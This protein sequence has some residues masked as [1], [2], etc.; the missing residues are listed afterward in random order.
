MKRLVFDEFAL[1]Q[2]DLKYKKHELFIE[3]LMHDRSIQKELFI[4]KEQFVNFSR[5]DLLSNNSFIVK[6]DDIPVG[7]I[8][9]SLISNG[10]VSLS[11][12][13]EKSFRNEGY[14]TLIIS[15]LSDYL[16][17][18]DDIDRISC[19]ISR[20]NYAS[21]ALFEKCGYDKIS[22]VYNCYEKTKKLKLMY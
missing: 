2:V 12:G 7:Y 6:I 15:Y 1:E 3:R 11:I 14:G 20:N 19:V 16:L 17:G 21:I 22:D 13:V 4:D 5:T 8:E 18:R 10:N 9:T